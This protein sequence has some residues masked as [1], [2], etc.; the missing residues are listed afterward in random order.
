MDPCGTPNSRY[1]GGN[2]VSPMITLW[3]RPCKYDKNH[4]RAMPEKPKYDLSLLTRRLWSSVSNAADRSSITSTTSFVRIE[5]FQNVIS[6]LE[7]RRLE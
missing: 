7:Q 6:Y 1:V 5:G 3:E 2:I 4:C